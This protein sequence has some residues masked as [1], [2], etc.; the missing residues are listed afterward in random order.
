MVHRKNNKRDKRNFKQL[1][2]KSFIKQYIKKYGYK[3]T[4]LE[5]F[6]LYANGS[7]NLTDKQE[8][9]FIK[10]FELNNLM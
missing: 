8:N 6:N 10:L 3:P 5:L 1:N 7:L 2:M 9:E 4:I